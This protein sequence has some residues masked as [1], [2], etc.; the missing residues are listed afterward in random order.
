MISL[1]LP[2]PGD[3]LILEMWISNF[4]KYEHLIDECL[5]CINHLIVV[6]K[7]IS[8]KRL[9]ELSLFYN[10]LNTSKIKIYY[11]HFCNNHGDALKFL[12]EKSSGDIIFLMEDDN[13]II[14]IEYLQI[15][16]E[17]VKRNE[18]DIV[19]VQ[20]NCCSD[21][22]VKKFIYIY[23][24]KNIGFWPTNFICKK[25]LLEKTDLNFSEKRFESGVFIKE[26][27]YTPDKHLYSDTMVYLSLQLHYLT[28]KIYY[29][30]KS[31][32]SSIN[33][34]LKN[35]NFDNKQMSDIHIGSLSSIFYLLLFDDI[36]KEP[37]IR[38]LNDYEKNPNTILEYMRRIIYLKLLLERVDKNQ[39][40]YNTYKEN[41][42]LIFKLGFKKYTFDDSIIK[43]IVNTI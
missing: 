4:K 10:S 27:N 7:S 39:F 25:S 22:L 16:L 41:I 34:L 14:D 40:Y 43:Q 26:L 23:N 35:T 28:N 33:D 11:N 18:Y 1:L 12:F 9:H 6:E 8:E 15:N 21:E 3:P 36:N 32:H 31:F 19:G 20:R 29:I 24:K 38:F 2:T 5:I 17:K 30:H 37:T 13:Y 42:E